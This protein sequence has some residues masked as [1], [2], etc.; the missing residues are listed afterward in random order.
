MKRVLV[1]G[2]TGFIGANLCRRLLEAGHEVHCLVRKGYFEWR[3]Q[4]IRQHLHLHEVDLADASR[5]N[6]AVSGVRPEWIFHLAAHGAYS[7]QTDLGMMVRTNIVSTVNL[8]EACLRTGFEVFVN[9][10]SSSEYGYKDH[11]PAETEWIDPNSYYAVTKASA[12]LFCR[13]SAIHHGVCI[14][15]LRLYS[16]YGPYENPGR[17]IPTIILRGL[18][19]ALPPLVDPD[20]A[21]DY[22]HVGDAEDAYLLLAAQAVGKDGDVFNLGSGTQTTVGEVVGIARKVFGLTA[23]P[24][25]G[26]LPRRPWDTTSWKANSDKLRATGWKPKI[27]FEQGFRKTVDWFRSHPDLVKYYNKQPQAA[28]S[29]S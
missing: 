28:D 2:A 15:T 25:W 12:T 7:W 19:G 18:Q 11:A 21:R 3:I 10:G 4:E 17:L 16:I 9:T 5:L 22:V 27:T 23:E 24:Q 20:T 14:P 29:N 6:S 26:T 13:Y 1:T 8:V